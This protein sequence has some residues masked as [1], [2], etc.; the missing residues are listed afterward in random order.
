[1]FKVSNK[2]STRE[3][4]LLLMVELVHLF[5]HWTRVSLNFVDASSQLNHVNYKNFFH[6]S[7]SNLMN[8]LSCHN[9]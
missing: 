5:T 6:S 7:K 8:E 9:A 1:M 3:P 4:Q 2:D